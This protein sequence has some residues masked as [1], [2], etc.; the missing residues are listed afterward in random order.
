MRQEKLSQPP[1]NVIAFDAASA[2]KGIMTSLRGALLALEHNPSLKIICVGKEK[3]LGES[4]EAILKKTPGN[5]LAKRLEIANADECVGMNE[6]PSLNV[7]RRKNTSIYKCVQFVVEGKADALVSPG[8]TGV[9]GLLASLKMGRLSWRNPSSFKDMFTVKPGLLARFPTYKGDEVSYL[10]DSGVVNDVDSQT[11][12]YFGLMMKPYLEKIDKKTNPRIAL[13]NIGTEKGKGDLLYKETYG[14]L[15]KY[16]E[17][18]LINFVG[19]QEPD[20]VLRHNAD[21][22]VCS[23]QVGNIFTKAA[24]AVSRFYENQIK[25][26]YKSQMIIVQALGGFSLGSI[27][28]R[29]KE[30]LDLLKLGGGLLLGTKHKA[31]ITHGNADEREL[32]GAI[33]YSARIKDFNL[34]DEITNLLRETHWYSRLIRK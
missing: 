3:E 7:I 27:K 21:G 16:A 20:D 26:N 15:E 6:K 28:D 31:I 2:E 34:N 25:E 30:K 29:L 14:L 1:T 13:L 22:F 10:C 4:L 8:N 23:A 9:T 24:E 19:N 32:A 11:L 18:G 33:L 17:K 12:S 5:E